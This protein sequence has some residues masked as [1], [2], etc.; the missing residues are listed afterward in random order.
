MQTIY[1]D[2]NSKQNARVKALFGLMLQTKKYTDP[3][4]QK[5]KDLGYNF[6]D[7][8]DN[9]EIPNGENGVENFNQ[10]DKKYHEFCKFMDNI[11][12]I[13]NKNKN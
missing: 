2:E 3:I 12:E 9:F 4:L 6:V 8:L 7:P 11:I 13:H 1:E 10:M 5:L